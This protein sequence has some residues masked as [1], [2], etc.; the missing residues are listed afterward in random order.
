[1]PSP[2]VRVT[3]AESLICDLGRVS[4]WCDHWGMKSNVSKIMTMI[5]S[6]ERTMHP[7]SHTLTIGGGTVLKE[8]DDLDV[9][10]VTFNSR[11]TSEKH[12]LSVSRAAAQGLG[13][14]RKSWRVFNDRSLLV[15]CFPGFVLPV[16]EY[17]SSVWCSAADTH[18]KLLDRVVSG[19]RF[20]T[21]S[22]KT[23][24][25]SRASLLSECGIVH[26]RF[27]AVLCIQ[28]EIRC[29]PMHPLYGALPVPY[30]PVRVARGALVAHRYTYAPSRCRTSKYRRTFI[31]LSVSL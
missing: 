31:A 8:F 1:M 11:M 6:S 5:V 14:L 22:Q 24:F 27:L 7:Q 3:V 19:A 25:F 12:L 4:E 21:A 10:G 29:N 17:C 13:I 2:G 28:Y 20:L 18:F 23:D 26:R 9:L 16:L 15:K 30:V